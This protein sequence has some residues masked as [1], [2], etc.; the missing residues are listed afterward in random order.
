MW[1]L[2]INNCDVIAIGTIGSIL[3]TV[4]VLVT[5]IIFYKVRDLFPAHSLFRGIV[6]SD[7]PCLIFTLRLTDMKREG[8]FLTPIP[9]YAVAS[10]QEEYEG[11]QL[12]PWIT[13]TSETQAVA[14]ILNI[15]GRVG[16]TKNIQI[17]FVD[18]DSGRWDAPMFIL[19]GNWKATR[20]FETCMPIFSYRDEKVILEST[21]DIY[22]PKTSDHDIGF[23]QKT[24]NPVTGFPVWVAMGWRGA[25]T[26]AAT[27]ALLRW[28][29]EI[30]ILYGSHPFGILIG[31]N[32]KDGWQQS[33][34]VRIYPEPK[35][36]KKIIHPIVWKR[37][38][39]AISDTSVTMTLGKST[40]QSAA[41]DRR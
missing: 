22:R 6:G 13:S 4:V 40:E 18:Q 31:M 26:V 34:I 19:G 3:A 39:K 7:L 35:C 32:D 1:N 10:P 33:H 27:Y 17:L 15:L 2:I 24:I 9:K 29:K 30:G 16:R 20:S 21:K 23:L 12:T 38:L 41:P 14:N 8:K 25:G 36:Y 28:W 37:I 5:R 11:R